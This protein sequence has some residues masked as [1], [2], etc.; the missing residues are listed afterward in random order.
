M[1]AKRE[2]VKPVADTD[3]PIKEAP[4]KKSAPEIFFSN[5]PLSANKNDILKA[6]G[7]HSRDVVL[8]FR[9]EPFKDTVSKR[10]GAVTKKYREGSE[11]ATKNCYVK[12][13]EGEDVKWWEEAKHGKHPIF[14][15]DH[16]LTYN[17]ASM[18]NDFSVFSHKKSIFIG[19]LPE[20][21][22]TNSIWDALEPLNPIGVRYITD[23]NT[24]KGQQFGFVLFG[25]RKTVADALKLSEKLQI[26]GK[27]VRIEKVD[28]H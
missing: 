8:R 3:D 27:T 5:V 12:F 24:G 4:E 26:D 21:A 23:V 7:R 25:E 11:T 19:G 14:I 10:V 13:K 28:H 9:G 15:D 22:S 1:A 6:I 16:R 2:D 17:P 20:S 18:G